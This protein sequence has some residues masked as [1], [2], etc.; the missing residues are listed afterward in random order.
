MNTGARDLACSPIWT[1]GANM[2]GRL[3]GDLPVADRGHADLDQ[4]RL[5]PGEGRDLALAHGA[6]VVLHAVAAEQRAGDIQLE[7]GR[8]PDDY[9]L[10]APA[11]CAGSAPGRP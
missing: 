1:N 10:R 11:R 6:A 7:I 4:R 5:L 8:D 2:C 3:N 9:A